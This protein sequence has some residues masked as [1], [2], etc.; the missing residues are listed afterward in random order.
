M[1]W[2][3][4]WAQLFRLN[5]RDS[6]PSITPYTRRTKDT[7]GLI[8]KPELHGYPGLIHG[9]FV[10]IVDEGQQLGPNSFISAPSR[11]EPPSLAEFEEGEIFEI[12]PTK[13]LI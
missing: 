12:L 7:G 8:S 10:G 11:Y 5:S 13:G 4:I 1:L 3:L 9:P 6:A 2:Q